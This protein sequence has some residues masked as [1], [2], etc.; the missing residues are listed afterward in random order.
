MLNPLRLTEYVMHSYAVLW[1]VLQFI[2]DDLPLYNYEKLIN[3]CIIYQPTK[4]LMINKN[5][6]LCP[7]TRS[8][9][10]CGRIV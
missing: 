1:N 6:V 2:N 4:V 8:V 9:S 3:T 10:L 5:S 7:P